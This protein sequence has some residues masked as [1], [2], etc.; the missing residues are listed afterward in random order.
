MCAVLCIMTIKVSCAAT[1]S[2]VCILDSSQH[3]NIS[4][5]LFVYSVKTVDGGVFGVCVTGH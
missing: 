4:T 1:L 5:I 2:D 3:F